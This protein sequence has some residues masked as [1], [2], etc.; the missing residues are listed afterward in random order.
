MPPSE[1]TIG[2]L[3]L[4]I[5]TALYAYYSV[6]ILVTRKQP[7]LPDSS[8]VQEWFPA[9]EWAVRFATLVLLT[10]FSTVAAVTG[11]VLI[12]TARKKKNVVKKVRRPS[13]AKKSI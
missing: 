1:A 3:L 4:A 10:G 7:L 12:E 9:R 11:W 13:L 6:W 5:V 2:Q 8:P